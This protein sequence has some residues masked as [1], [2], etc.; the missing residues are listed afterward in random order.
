MLGQQAFSILYSA[1]YRVTSLREA[2]LVA[3]L[4]FLTYYL[5]SLGNGFL[6]DLYYA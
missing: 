4:F 5:P 1:L 6:A 3:Q 2:I